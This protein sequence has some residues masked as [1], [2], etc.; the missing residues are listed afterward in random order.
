MIEP[1]NIKTR[2][3]GFEYCHILFILL[4]EPFQ[5]N[6]L[7]KFFFLQSEFAFGERTMGILITIHRLFINLIFGL[8]NKQKEK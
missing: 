4:P 2:K 5:I 8:T 6:V 7:L 1:E 3:Y